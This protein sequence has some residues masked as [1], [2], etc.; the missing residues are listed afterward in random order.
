MQCTL[1][2]ILHVWLYNVQGSDV[3]KYW[4][5]ITLKK[6]PVSVRVIRE[7]KTCYSLELGIYLCAVPHLPI[8][9]SIWM[10]IDMLNFNLFCVVIWKDEPDCRIVSGLSD[11]K[12]FF[13]IKMSWV[14]MNSCNIPSCTW[15]YV[16]LS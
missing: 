1:L 8:L 4:K 2:L 13:F 3:V 7:V 9:H 14:S 12:T 16:N 6:P 15:E 10:V 11:L 5:K